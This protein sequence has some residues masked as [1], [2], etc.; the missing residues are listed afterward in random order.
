MVNPIDGGMNMNSNDYWQMFMETGAPEL[1][2]LYHKA[3]KMENT[4][5]FD[6]SGTGSAGQGIQ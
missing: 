3:Q 2:L 1:Y 5:V 6:G 4:N